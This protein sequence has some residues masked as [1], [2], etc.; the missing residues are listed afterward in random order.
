VAA[1]RLEFGSS[2]MLDEGYEPNRR[3]PPVS[4]RRG[5]AGPMASYC[6]RV[7]QRFVLDG[8]GRE[9]ERG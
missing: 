8:P 4:N 3:G 1:H 2:W 9:I 7:E 5:R 6:C